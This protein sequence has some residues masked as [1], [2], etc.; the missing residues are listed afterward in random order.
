MRNLEVTLSLRGDPRSAVRTPFVVCSKPWFKVDDILAEYP[1]GVADWLQYHRR[2][3]GVGRFWLYDIDGSLEVNLPLSDMAHVHYLPRWTN[4]FPALGSMVDLGWYYFA[5]SLTYDHCLYSNLG[6]AD[7]IIFLHGL[8]A[9][10]FSPRLSGLGVHS[11]DMHLNL[12]DAL[13]DKQQKLLRK[14]V[15]VP[16]LCGISVRRCEFGGTRQEGGLVEAF[17]FRKMN[18]TEHRPGE[19]DEPI[20]AADGS[21]MSVRGHR[22]VCRHFSPSWDIMSLTAWRVNHYQDALVNS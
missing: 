14:F 8:D 4:K 17:G 1:S 12:L 7:W 9:F 16:P 3:V 10:Y 19:M 20:I 2:V 5:E 22:P 15:K 13:E 18:C 11:A 6:A 21:A